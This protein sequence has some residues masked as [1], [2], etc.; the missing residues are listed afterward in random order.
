MSS[1]VEYRGSPTRA[2]RRSG[3]QLA[4]TV[5]VTLAFAT[6][7]VADA[8]AED[9]APKAQPASQ[10]IKGEFANSCAMGLARKEQIS[11]DCSI[12][13]KAGDG[14]TYCFSNEEAKGAFLKDPDGNLAKAK[15]FYAEAQKL[16]SNRGTLG[17]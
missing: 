17:H 5:L 8:G 11:T 3:F 7:A 1:T 15:E 12:N 10:S 9:A 14:K 13:W 16:R 6:L 2:L 4:R